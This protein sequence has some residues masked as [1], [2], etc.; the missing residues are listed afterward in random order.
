LIINI[1]LTLNQSAD[2]QNYGDGQT[3]YTLVSATPSAPSSVL[4]SSGNVDLG[5]WTGWDHS[6]YNENVDI[7]F[8][9]DANATINLANGA[10]T[11]TLP[12]HYATQYGQAVTITGPNLSMMNWSLHGTNQ[13]EIDDQDTDSNQYTYCPAIELQ[14]PG[15]DVYYVQLD[16]LI[17]NVPT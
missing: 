5:V 9:L 17:K 4:D 14:I 3:S 1:S 12:M 8:T 16:P 7:T 10:G 13:L 15:R 2:G 11:T 6:Q